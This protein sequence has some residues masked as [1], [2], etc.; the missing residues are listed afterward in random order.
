[1]RWLSP[2]D[3]RAAGA[4]EVEVVEPDIVEEAEARVD[5]L[6]DRAG[7]LAL[8]RGELFVEGREPGERVVDRAAGGLAEMSSPA[9]LTLSGSG[10]RR[11]PPQVSH[12]CDDW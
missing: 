8:L 12:G 3:K 5:F 4:V 6:E 2:P 10:R 7:D 11:A 9:I 1:M